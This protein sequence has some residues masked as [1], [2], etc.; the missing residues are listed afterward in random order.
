MIIIQYE[1]IKNLFRVK[2]NTFLGWRS[3]SWLKTSLAYR[4]I[5]YNWQI[6]MDNP[7]QKFYM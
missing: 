1:P 7:Q 4:G 6:V 2:T 3:L 5:P